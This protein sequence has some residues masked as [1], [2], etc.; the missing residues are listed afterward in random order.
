MLVARYVAIFGTPGHNHT[1][2]L[3]AKAFLPLLHYGTLPNFCPYT[4]I[5]RDSLPFPGNQWQV[6]K[7]SQSVQSTTTTTAA[8]STITRETLAAKRKAFQENKASLDRRRAQV[9]ARVR[10]AKTIAKQRIK[11]YKE[12][13]ITIPNLLSVSRI[14]STPLLGF[15]VCTGSYSLALNLFTY[16]AVTDLLDGQIARRWPSQQSMAGT[17]LDPLADKV[18]VGTLFL[19]LTYAGLIPIQLTMLAIFRDVTLMAA[20]FYLRFKSLPR[21]KTLLRY[22]DPS[23]ASIKFKPT[24][25][26]KANTT[27]QLGLCAT[28]L[29]AAVFQY[30]DHPAFYALWW[31]TAATTFASGLE[32]AFRKDTYRFLDRNKKKSK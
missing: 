24:F 26:S 8:T 16:A 22:F 7:Y 13:I 21:P 32:Y 23:I 12:N 4:S 31:L 1:S 25:L 14:V 20:S 9:T 15:W 2:L 27:I 28:T 17:V 30:T 3:R 18:L 10:L 6:R 11:V 29:G 5:I 19:T